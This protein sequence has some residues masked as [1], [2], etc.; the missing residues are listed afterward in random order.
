MTKSV[1]NNS[2]K[3]T[4]TWNLS[5]FYSSIKDKKIDSDLNKISVEAS[6]FAKKFTKKITKLNAKQLT[7]AIKEYE[8]ICELIGKV[9]SYSYLI[10]ASDLSNSD[11]LSFYQNISEKISE[12]ESLLVFF[13]LEINDIEEKT[14]NKFYKENST[15][16]SYYPFIRDVR[17][18]KQHQLSC[19]LEKFSLE[20]NSSGRAAWIRLFDETVN[21]LKFTY[22]K[23]TLNSQ[24]IFDLLSNNDEKIRKDAAKAI[25]K[26]F[27]DNAKIFAYIT[28][29]LAKEKSVEDQWRNFKNPISS[30]NL[31]N[32]VEDEV[33]DTLVLKVKENYKNISHRYYKIKAKILGKKTLNYWDRNAPLSKEEN[34]LISWNEAK[35]IV[36]SAY[37]EFDPRMSKIGKEF[38]DKN[39]ID[40]QVRNGKDSGAFSHSTV[41]SI[42]PY[43]LMNYQG[44]VRDVMTL[45]HELGHGIHQYLAKKQG[46][47]MCSTPLTLAETASV[48]GEQLTF[49]KI[50]KNEKDS[51]KRKI[52]IAN[53]VEDMINTAVRQIAFLEFEKKI[54]NERKKGEISLDKI[55]QF[56]M[57]VQKE[58]LGSAFKFDEEYKFF[59]S[60][61]PHFIHSPFYVYSY[62]FGDC[63][64]NSLY[65]VYKNKKVKNFEQKYFEMLEFGGTKHHKE[66]LEPFGLNANDPEFWQSGLNVIIEYINQLEK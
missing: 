40:A 43:I 30:R 7:E 15:L 53:K 57:E 22:R 36:L 61:I 63:L 28:N 24:E 42:H 41:P 6:N 9:S 23:K 8:K 47:L 29:V 58:S 10:Y 48:F 16:K 54:H 3:N 37:E 52:I 64:V 13:S 4:P 60:Y 17:A 26:T 12:Y 14:L 38:F 33:V 50:L 59:W 20:K 45:A 44:K 51:Q 25:G 27:G 18:F 21:N 34:K 11:N 66:M 46:A 5:D 2:L 19:E 35:K 56:W 62:A 65:G 39:W 49:Q 32:F 1:K 55:C 31:S